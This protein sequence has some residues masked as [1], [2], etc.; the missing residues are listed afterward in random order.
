MHKTTQAPLSRKFIF[1]CFLILAG[2][3]LQY[4]A[5]YLIK[6][7]VIPKLP[8]FTR[9]KVVALNQTFY[10]ENYTS[11]IVRKNENCLCSDSGLFHS[12]KRL[13]VSPQTMCYRKVL[14]IHP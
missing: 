10:A 4:T 2:V 12:A 14:K 3:I 5:L 1:V 8:T 6:L 9:N 11:T 7:F 13:L